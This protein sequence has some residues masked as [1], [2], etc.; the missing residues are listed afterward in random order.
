MECKLLIDRDVMYEMTLRDR[1]FWIGNR[2]SCE[3]SS[4]FRDASSYRGGI[5][6]RSISNDVTT[7]I[8]SLDV[9]SDK[10]ITR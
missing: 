8:A 6:A 7:T 10:V 5:T 3:I 4:V 9:T 2:G 1:E